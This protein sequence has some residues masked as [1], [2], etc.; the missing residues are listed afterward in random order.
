MSITA[1]GPRAL[2]EGY[3]PAPFN[4][5]EQL[6]HPDPAALPGTLAELRLSLPCLLRERR[7][8]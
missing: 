1:S 3:P 8:A 5:L 2:L 4:T 7:A 6:Q